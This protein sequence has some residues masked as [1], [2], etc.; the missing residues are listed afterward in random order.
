[1]IAVVRRLSTFDPDQIM[2][3]ADQLSSI[4]LDFEAEV[5]GR[6]GPGRI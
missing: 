3:L 6:G 1:M 5:T 4:R 2:K